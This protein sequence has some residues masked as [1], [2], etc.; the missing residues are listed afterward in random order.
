MR[1]I[2]IIVW[3]L[4]SMLSVTA[5]AE[6][7]SFEASIERKEASLGNPT[8]LYLNFYGL[9]DIR[10]PDIDPIDGLQIRYVGPS[11]KMSIINGQ[12]SKSITHTYMIIPKKIG[13]YK[14]GPFSAD[15]ENK[16]YQTKA[17]ELRVTDKPVQS[18]KVWRGPSASSLF[19]E[20]PEIDP[21]VSDRIFLTM[22]IAKTLVYVNEVVPVTMKVYVNAVGIRDGEYPVYDHEGFS[23]G[24][25]K[26]PDRVRELVD[27]VKYDVL[28]FKQNL[29][30]IRDG[31]YLLGPAKWRG[32][33]VI[34]KRTRS[35]SFFGSMFG[36]Y[37][38]YPIE[39]ESEEL[40]VSV[41]S[42]PETGKPLTFSGAVGSFRMEANI[43]QREVKVGDPVVLRTVI[44]GRGNFDT[45]TPPE[46]GSSKDFKAYEPQVEKKGNV[47][48]YEQILIPTNHEVYEIPK[49]E[50]SF[51]DPQTGKYETITRGPFPVRVIERPESEKTVKMV[52]MPGI[53][54]TLYPKEK[55]GKDI[56]YIK[57]K[58]GKVYKKGKFI[59][60]NF[61]FF[62]SQIVPLLLFIG[63]YSVHRKRERIL[64]D[65]SYAKLL[66][67]P[68]KARKGMTRAKLL[69]KKGDLDLFYDSVFKTL[70]DYFGG[71]FNLPK[72]NIAVSRIE[73]YVQSQ[74]G[75]G[76][77]IK[78]LKDV[79]SKCEMARYA[80]SIASKEEA[81]EM[82]EKIKKIIDYFE[83][84]RV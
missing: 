76:D 82:L 39:L 73:Q 6:D 10:R 69:L 63:F 37:K 84:A 30:P 7:I 32:T 54:E 43:D 38:T 24:E 31:D 56:I 64:K 65:K 3:V 35:S 21:Y 29:V 23:S 79:F 70:Q 48:T 11:T 58:L 51:F 2:F 17:L 52:S 28:V 14:I 44:S 8:Y 66:K 33:L 5:Q 68:R 81:S 4:I 45:V 12:V 55:L 78:E 75:S 61:M 57:S 74:P 71:R 25:I 42:L 26:E 15:H 13:E 27:G 80:S 16:R 18:N 53:E 46:L 34:Q 67:A 59:Y 36:G 47:K 41:L 20:E 50:F 22:D 62:P 77:I 40:P 49:I 83:K 1:K 72:G 9:Q 19:D 60:K